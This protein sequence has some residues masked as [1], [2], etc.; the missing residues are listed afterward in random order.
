MAVLGRGVGL[1]CLAAADDRD[2]VG[3]VGAVELVGVRERARI[4]RVAVGPVVVAGRVVRRLR[5]GGGLGVEPGHDHDAVVVGR[6]VDGRLDLVVAAEPAQRAVEREQAAPGPCAEAAV[7]GRADVVA[8]LARGGDRALQAGQRV[9]LA[10]DPRR[11]RELAVQRRCQRPR[12]R[13]GPAGTGRDRAVRRG[14]GPVGAALH[15]GERSRGKP[16]GSEGDDHP[17]HPDLG[18]HRRQ[19]SRAR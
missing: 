12:G 18:A 17:D 2:Q 14:V 5:G 10:D 7:V 13:H 3:V 16:N 1:G 6:R 9:V 8:V 15:V 11:P 4:T 19:S